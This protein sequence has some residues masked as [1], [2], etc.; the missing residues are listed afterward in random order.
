VPIT[1]QRLLRRTALA[2]AAVTLS[3]VA[4]G[5]GANFNAQT[6]QP[7]QAAEGTD[8]MSGPIA[9]RNMLVLA[10]EDGKGRLYGSIVNT[11]QEP[12]RL[13]GIA[14]APADAGDRAAGT[15]E[16]VTFGGVRSVTL[17]P[18]ESL[19]LPPKTG[20]PITVSGGE[21][22]RMIKVTIT[23]G[24]AAP[25]TASVPVLTEDH[26]SPSPRPEASPSEGETEG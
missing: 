15:P 2:G 17:Q 8:A 1:T 14:A 23:F 24:E 18:G 25:I 26:Y 12:D 16:P 6:Q 4:A 10:S 19:I 3:I 20:G 22:G 9:V 11:G 21:P 5:C 13:V 7:Y